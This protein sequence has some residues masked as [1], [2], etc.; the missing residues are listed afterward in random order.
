MFTNRSH[1]WFASAALATLL[2]THSD[3]DACGC[4]S[5]PVPQPAEVTLAVNVS[6]RQAC[7]IGPKLRG[8]PR[9]C[10]ARNGKTRYGTAGGSSTTTQS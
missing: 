5:P 1:A 10:E 4:F 7:V 8:Y 9:R 2:Y 3:A 6:F